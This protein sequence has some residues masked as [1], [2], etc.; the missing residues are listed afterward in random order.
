[1]TNDASFDHVLIVVKDLDNSIEFYDL[2]GFKHIETIQR[3]NDRVA[4][5][6]MGQVKIEL[7]C[8]P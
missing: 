7:M 6:Q 1:M 2:I 8:L 3:P 4:V 5:M